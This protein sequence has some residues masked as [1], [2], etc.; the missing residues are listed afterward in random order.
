MKQLFSNELCI[1]FT[2]FAA[3]NPLRKKPLLSGNLFVGILLSV[4]VLGMA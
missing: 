2:V 3:V 1:R 4:W